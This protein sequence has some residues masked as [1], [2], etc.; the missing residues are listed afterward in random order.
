MQNLIRLLKS[1]PILSNLGERPFPL[2]SSKKQSFNG[3][4]WKLRRGGGFAD[5]EIELGPYH[6]HPPTTC[7]IMLSIS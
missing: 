6:L 2:P 1:V 5:S 4:K 3:A 7:Y